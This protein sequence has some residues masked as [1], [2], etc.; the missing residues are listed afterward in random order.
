[1]IIA[2]SITD[3]RVIAAVQSGELIVARTDTIYGI[4]TT[5]THKQAIATLYRVRHRS[6][7]KPC[8]ILIDNLD[9]IPDLTTTQRQTYSKLNHERPTTIVVPVPDDFLP[10]TPRCYHTLAFRVVDG[11]LAEMIKQVGPL[12][13]PS[14]NPEGLPPAQNIDEAISYFG[15]E[16]SIYVDGGHATQNIPSRIIS[17]TNDTLEIIRD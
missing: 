3:P 10:H 7:H 1:M 8:I 17:F 15:E 6:A 16:V 2:N 9:V 13:A 11:E 5:A 12:L 4:M 14:A